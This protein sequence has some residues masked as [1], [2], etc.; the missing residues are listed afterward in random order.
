MM[1]FNHGISPGELFI[2]VKTSVTKKDIPR[3]LKNHRE[4]HESIGIIFANAF[5][6]IIDKLLDDK[7]RFL[8]PGTNAYIDFDVVTGESF[9]AFRKIGRFLDVDFIES[10]FTGYSL[11]YYFKLGGSTL[12]KPLYVGGALK[13]KFYERINR[14][15]KFYSIRDFVLDDVMDKIA[16]T[17]PYIEREELKRLILIGFKR[18]HRAIL[19]GAPI[20]IRST[21]VD[22]CVMFIGYIKNVPKAARAYYIK[23]RNLKERLVSKWREDE[24]EGFYYVCIP[25]SKILD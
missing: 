15:E 1:L 9:K 21:A 5:K 4:L 8:V 2:N 24:F 10:D 7:L 20:T 16:D 13:E 3:N 25:K 22:N 23:S 12:H 17:F 14:G 6:I 19:F 18:I 11:R